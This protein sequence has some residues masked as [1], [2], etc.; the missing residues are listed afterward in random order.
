MIFYNTPPTKS[1]PSAPY[2]GRELIDTWHR[3]RDVSSGLKQ[4]VNEHEILS[5]QPR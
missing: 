1:A 3:W 2:T 4:D 5:V